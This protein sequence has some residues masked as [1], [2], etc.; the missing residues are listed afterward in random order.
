MR[1]KFDHLAKRIKGKVDVLM[2]PE[3]KIANTFPSR[4][5]YI[6]GF[7]PSYRL[8]RNCHASG[9]LVYVREDIPSKLTET[10]SLVESI[11]IELN[12]RK[13]KW[14]VNCSYNTNNSNIC[15][16]LRSLG[17]GLNPLLTNY[18]KMFLMGD[19]NAEEASN[20]IKDCC[21]LCKLKDLIK[22]PTCFKNPDNLRTIDLM[23]TNSGRTF[24]N[25]CARETCLSDFIYAPKKKK[26]LR[27]NN[28]PFMNK[29]ISIKLKQ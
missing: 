6:E 15:D 29:A 5:F 21:N 17:K 20:S 25:L 3:T 12:L 4:Q 11:F 28:S 1:N 8:G 23:L 27:A 13:K 18:G 26:Y 16:H 2:I 7:T 24:H 9:I 14:P 22:V 10:N 19:F